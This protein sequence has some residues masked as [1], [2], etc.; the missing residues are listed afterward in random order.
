MHD[1]QGAG[2]G[3]EAAQP[4]LV[5]GL[6]ASPGSAAELTEALVAEVAD[7]LAMQLPGVRWKVEFL[8]DRL[9]EP[10]TD[11]TE[12]ISAGRR[13]LLERGWNLVVCVTDLPLQTARR[14]VIAH[15][16]ATHGVAVL[17]LP[18]LGP[19]AV[20]RR[21]VETIVRLA[22]HL[23]GDREQ[24]ADDGGRRR[25]LARVVRRRM[26]E[27]SRR[28]EPGEH[29]MRLVARVVTGN[30][31]LLLGMLRAN[32]PWR[33]ALRLVRALVAAVAAGVFAL[34]TSD[35]WRLA[36]YLGTLRLTV[37]GVGSVAATSVTI[38]IAT[39]LWERSPQRSARDQVIMFNIVTAVTVGIGV[40]VLYAAVFAAMLAAALLLVP[41]SLLVSVLGHPAGVADQV[42]LAWL[43]TSIATLGGALGAALETHETVR[44]AAYTFHPDT[45][46][47]AADP[48]GPGDPE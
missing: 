26:V 44:E 27:L 3:S 19:V 20:R 6:L 35:I 17:S 29:G 43:A 36:G 30:I 23:L 41:A 22:G 12:V 25:P 28:V 40:A 10:P 5:V 21:A 11:L 18:A 14:P 9:V 48:A 7:R 1:L 2:E 24:A 45:R 42:Q 16:S 15:V 8:I 46:L 34:V 4:D 37:I 39:G 47:E 13:M 31:W 38:V 32:R 33:L